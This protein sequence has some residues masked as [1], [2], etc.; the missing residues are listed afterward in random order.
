MNGNGKSRQKLNAW[1]LHRADDMMDRIYGRRK[2]SIWAGLPDVVVEIGPGTGANLRYYAPGTKVIAIEPNPAMHP[3]LA[4]AS[5]K[6]RIDLD[7][8]AVKGE[9]ID[10][11]ENAVSAVVGTLVLCTVDR[12]RQVIS[13]V[14]RILKPGGRYLFL[15]HVSASPGT[16]LR[17]LQEGLKRPWQW[18]F[19]GCRLNRDTYRAIAG[20][21]FSSVDMDCFM[22]KT[23]LLPF[24][25][26]I[27]GVAVK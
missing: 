23:Q 14:L 6:Y 11:P 10:L 27:F 5:R 3:H 17:G 7:I 16:G 24:A 8:R 4:K 9:T 19:D 15:E 22:M 20:A 26:H 21:G 2:R 18:L 1:L 12:P 13:E 25:P